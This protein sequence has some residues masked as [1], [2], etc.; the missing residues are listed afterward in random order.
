[1]RRHSLSSAGQTECPLCAKT[2]QSAPQKIA[3][4][5]NND[6]L[7]PSLFSRVRQQLQ[8]RAHACALRTVV[9][10]DLDRLWWRRDANRRMAKIGQRDGRDS[11]P[12]RFWSSTDANGAYPIAPVATVWALRRRKR[13]RELRNP[14]LAFLGQS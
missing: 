10:S 7:P 9:R 3:A 6:R 11:C 13:G 8:T 14:A 1:M 4:E 5:L 12:R 2:Q